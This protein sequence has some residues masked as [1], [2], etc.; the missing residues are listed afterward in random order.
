[1]LYECLQPS[2]FYTDIK[3]YIYKNYTEEEISRLLDIH[4]RRVSPINRNNR[5]YH[6]NFFEDLNVATYCVSNEKLFIKIYDVVKTNNFTELPTLINDESKLL[7]SVS[8]WRLSLG[9]YKIYP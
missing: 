4:G 8:K 3:N 7:A 9:T 1:M 2:T 6:F 5:I